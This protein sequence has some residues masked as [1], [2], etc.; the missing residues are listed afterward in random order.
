[1]RLVTVIMI[2]F[3]GA[4][5]PIQAISSQSL[6]IETTAKSVFLF[7]LTANKI[8]F[9]KEPDVMVPLASL[10]KLMTALVLYEKGVPENEWVEFKAGD[11]RNGNI[12]Y[13]IPG[14]EIQ[15][16]D[17]WNLMLMASSNDAVMALVRTSG[18]IEEEFVKSM[19]QKARQLGLRRLSFADPTGLNPANTGS[20]REITALARVA[21][22]VPKIRETLQ[23]SQYVF[24]PRGKTKR[25][26]VATNLLLNSFI[27]Q[28]PYEMIGGKT[29][30]VEESRYNMVF[31]VRQKSDNRQLMGA[32]LGS[33]TSEDRSQEVKGL[34]Y[35][36]FEK[37]R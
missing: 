31:A 6:G 30:Y 32:L 24:T 16:K 29:G 21:L 14:E 9:V 27:N 33:E 35:W 7:D 11:K 10:T 17:L 2:L 22:S 34:I 13:L 15:K 25:K 20:A 5:H 4:I 26:A 12:P 3:F 28:D 1:M 8:V 18:F 37:A 36:G 23:K 19:N